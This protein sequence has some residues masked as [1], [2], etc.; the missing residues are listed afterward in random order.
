[1]TNQTETNKQLQD[2]QDYLYWLNK[3]DAWSKRNIYKKVC[4]DGYTQGIEDN[5][6]HRE[7]TKESIV[8]L[9]GYNPFS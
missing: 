5:K 3:D 4:V 2:L 8:S 1:M 7:D 6:Q 9:L